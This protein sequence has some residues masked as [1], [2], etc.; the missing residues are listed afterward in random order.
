MG[1]GYAWKQL[2]HG[3]FENAFNGVWVPD[4][5]LAAVNQAGS[6]LTDKIQQEQ[7]A[8]LI[9]Q[10]Q[11]NQLLGQLSPNTDSRDYWT[12]AGG[13]T[14]LQEFGTSLEESATSIGQF[15]SKAINKTLGLGF[16]IIPWQ[17]KVLAFV[18][19]LIWLYPF[20][21]PFAASLMKQK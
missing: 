11:A 8:G 3:N 5:Q 10:D 13:N 4:S 21:K 20:W 19:I 16:S 14:P 2:I 15:G 9:N 7:A 18:L 1:L 17:V 12:Q 6:A